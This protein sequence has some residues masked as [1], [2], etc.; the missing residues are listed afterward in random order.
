VILYGIIAKSHEFEHSFRHLPHILIK[1][2]MC[3]TLLVKGEFEPIPESF[4]I[5]IK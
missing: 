4:R 3:W 5:L 2:F 1:Y